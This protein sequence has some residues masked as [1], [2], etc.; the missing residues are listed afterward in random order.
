MATMS[1]GTYVGKFKNG[2]YHGKGSLTLPDNRILKGIWRKNQ[3]V[4]KK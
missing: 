4:W 3:L 1:F 2:H